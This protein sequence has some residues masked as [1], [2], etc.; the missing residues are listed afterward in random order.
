M[1]VTTVIMF[2][3]QLLIKVCETDKERKIFCHITIYFDISRTSFII[4]IRVKSTH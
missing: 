4:K 1:S 3:E 2:L